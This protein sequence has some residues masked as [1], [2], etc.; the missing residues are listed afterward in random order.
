MR[1]WR[2]L[3]WTDRPAHTHEIEYCCANGCMRESLLPVA[4][5]PVAQV[6]MGLVF[7]TSERNMP[8]DIQCP[9]CRRSYTSE[10]EKAR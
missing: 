7:D 3:R 5:T 8:Q 1:K 4:G 2:I 6:G 10:H 9:W